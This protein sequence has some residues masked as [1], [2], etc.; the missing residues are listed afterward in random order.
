MGV[1]KLHV[2]LVRRLCSPHKEPPCNGG[3]SKQKKE[4][5]EEKE[6][7]L[8]KHP[9]KLCI[10]WYGSNSAMQDTPSWTIPGGIETAVSRAGSLLIELH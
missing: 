3:S 5:E 8:W 2:I 1:T 7:A 9:T 4:E 10:A 6:I